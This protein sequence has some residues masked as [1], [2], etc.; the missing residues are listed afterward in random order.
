MAKRL[1]KRMDPIVGLV[2]ALVIFVLLAAGAWIGGKML[3]DYRAGKLQE[4]IDAVNDR[5]AALVAQYEEEKADYL[6]QISNKEGNKAWPTPAQEGWDVVD[7]TTYPLEAPGT[8]TISRTDAMF[9][10]L[11]LVNEWHSRP[12]DF[13]ESAMV[14]IHSY[15]KDAGL[16]SFWDNASC[17][18]HP[19]AIDALVALLT[20]AKALGYDHFVVREGY[21]FRSYEDQNELFTAELEKQRSARPSLTDE[22]LLARAKKNVN[23]PGTSEFNTG[24]SFCLKLYERE[25]GEAKTY[26]KETPFYDTPDG[27][28]LIENAWKYGF[29]FR[30]PTNNY[31]TADTVDKAYKTGMNQS[32]NCYRYVGKGHA[33]VMNHLGL[34]LEEYI[35]YLM[36]HP[37][38]AVFENGVKRYEITY[39]HV[40]DDVA[41]FT[42]DINRLTNNYTMTLDNMGGIITVYEY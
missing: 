27:Q 3:S 13:D 15:A 38:I 22:Q 10:G 31:P 35:E 26:Y 25:E 30:F 36:D 20:D 16:E 37:H 33:A 39:Q 5:N 9:G 12:A 17:K 6:A 24:L 41:T 2:I 1:K 4:E 28:W 34:C 23:Y 19:A 18:L 11:L 29:V 14:A 32:L 42:V 8:V 7:L 21:N 40:G